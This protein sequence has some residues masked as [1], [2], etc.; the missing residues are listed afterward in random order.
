MKDEANFRQF[1]K[2]KG[3]KPHVIEGLVQGVK[4]FEIHL[5]GKGRSPLEKTKEQDVLE[6]A[7]QLE[8]N[9]LK[10]RMR[11]LALYFQFA[12]CQP[13]VQVANSL[14][15]EEISKSRQA[16]K[17]NE[18]RGVMKEVIARLEAKGITSAEEMLV[19]GATP[20][21]RQQLA[22]QTEIPTETILELVKL[23][24]L[25]R[26]EGVKGVRARLYYEAGVDT[27][28]KI[29]RW[30]PEALREMLVK[31]VEHSKFEGIAPLP[32][33][34]SSTIAKARQLPKLV[35]YS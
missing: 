11:S 19:A 16:F 12:G 6:Y 28:E 29:A 13:L 25:S 31:F 24:D 26:L 17:L 22:K 8:I 1:L 3:K 14:R 18:F 7:S 34:I 15:E 2:K 27:P 23:S 5:A 32:K 30:E 10:E 4:M 35:K 21:S 20:E 9:K 33:E